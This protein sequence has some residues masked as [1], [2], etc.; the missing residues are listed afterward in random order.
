MFSELYSNKLGFSRLPS[1]LKVFGRGKG[2]RSLIVE[3]FVT[4]VGLPD[5]YISCVQILPVITLSR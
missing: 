4:T 5:G 2:L 1:G 3:I